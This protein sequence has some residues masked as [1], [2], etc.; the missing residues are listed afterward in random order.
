MGGL[1]GAGGSDGNAIGSGLYVA[2]GATVSLKKSNVAGN[3]ASTS[4]DDTYGTV[5]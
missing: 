1:S 2:T 5:T 4:N 3:F